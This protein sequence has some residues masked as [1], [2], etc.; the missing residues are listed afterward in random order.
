M[1]VLENKCEGKESSGMQGPRAL[2]PALT[3]CVV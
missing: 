3:E 2:A 1:Y